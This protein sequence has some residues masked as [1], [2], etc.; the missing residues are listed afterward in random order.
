MCELAAEFSHLPWEREVFASL[1]VRWRDLAR[2]AEEDVSAFSH[3]EPPAD[4]SAA[5][6]VPE[7]K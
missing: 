4:T 5:N 3:D 2:K 1:A 7:A 6:L